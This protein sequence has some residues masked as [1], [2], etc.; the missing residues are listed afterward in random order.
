MIVTEKNNGSRLEERIVNSHA[1]YFS[2]SFSFT[3]MGK[4]I[5]V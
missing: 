3:L 2:L 5:S 1:K 4:D